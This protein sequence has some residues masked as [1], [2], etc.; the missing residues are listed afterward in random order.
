M[1]LKFL[2]TWKPLLRDS[3]FKIELTITVISLVITLPCLTQFLNYIELR[4][5]VQLPDPFLKLFNPVDLTWFTFGVI[6]LSL[7]YAIIYLMNKPALLLSA[8]QS[9]VVMILFRI[10]AMYSLPLEPPQ[11]MIPLA[12]PFVEY[13][14]TG[15]LLTKDLFF[16]G[17]TAT[18]FLL[19]L[20]VDKKGIKMVFLLASIAVG[21][22]LLIQHVHYTVDVIAAPFF[23][24]GAYRLIKLFGNNELKL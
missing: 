1:N 23:S 6:Y 18:L 21:A 7:G 15:K 17:H 10:A 2:R 24:Y 8:I 22:A 20:I 3:K 5:G 13:F 14:G 16:S 19:L 11:F 12:D 4:N 9:Y